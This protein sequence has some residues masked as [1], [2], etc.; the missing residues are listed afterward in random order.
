MKQRID[1]DSLH[2]CMRLT[3]NRIL[4]EQKKK[5][6]S[7]WFDKAHEPIRSHT[8]RRLYQHMLIQLL[9]LSNDYTE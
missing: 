7:I 9:L 2:M 1:H 5:I 4:L 6:D 3:S 8:Y